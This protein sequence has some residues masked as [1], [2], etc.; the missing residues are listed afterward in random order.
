M[1][2]KE[3]KDQ[4]NA[5][6]EVFNF[7]QNRTPIRVQ[8]IN[9][10]PWFVAKDVCEVLGIVNHKDAASRLDDDE[11]RGS[12]MPTPSGRQECKMVNES[13]LYSLIFQSRKPE[14]RAFRKWVTSEVLP[15]IRKRGYYGV[16][17]EKTD[18]ID[19]QD[20]PYTRKMYNDTEVRCIDVESKEWINLGDLF[21]AIGST[22]S[23]SQ[24]VKKLNA[25]NIHAV[26]IMLFGATHPG[27]FVDTIGAAL[28]VSGSRKIQGY[29]Q[30]QLPF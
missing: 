13:G 1:S 15:S 8:V 5:L 27:W 20:T 11:T 30:L 7:S 19:A 3:K 26:K 12:V 23:V 29:R 17:R 25:K 16:Y 28:L 18:Y 21:R 6:V 22:T 2:N 9:N 10:E 24:S 4:P 14:A